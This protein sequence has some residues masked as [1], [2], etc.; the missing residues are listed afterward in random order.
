MGKEGTVY[1]ISHNLAINVHVSENKDEAGEQ[2]SI[3]TTIALHVLL[4]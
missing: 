1:G 3:G 2:S 4:R